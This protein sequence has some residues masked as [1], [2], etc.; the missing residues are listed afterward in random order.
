MKTYEDTFR[1]SSKEGKF[2][3]YKFF[4]EEKAEQKAESLAEK[5]EAMGRWT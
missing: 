4:T 1:L 3:K 2:P 5:A